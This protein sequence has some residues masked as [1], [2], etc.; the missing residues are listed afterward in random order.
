VELIR[1]PRK[2]RHVVEEPTQ[3]EEEG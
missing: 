2:E 3:A 1:K